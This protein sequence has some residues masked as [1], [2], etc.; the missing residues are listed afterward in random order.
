M[1]YFC[2]PSSLSFFRQALRK[3]S[4]L[5]LH[6]HYNFFNLNPA[7]LSPASSLCPP[8]SHLD[9]QASNCKHVL[10]CFKLFDGS[11]LPARSSPVSF[12]W[13]TSPIVI[14]PLLTCLLYILSLSP[15]TTTTTTK[16]A[17]Q[18]YLT[19]WPQRCFTPLFI[20]T[21]VMEQKEFIHLVLAEP[22]TKH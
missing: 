3:T 11:P 10:S 6:P 8:S 15:K 20:C 1:T 18:S 9:L 12:T 19:N 4:S 21:F 14:W 5:G 17:F 2:G 16:H 22:K 7:H 13:H